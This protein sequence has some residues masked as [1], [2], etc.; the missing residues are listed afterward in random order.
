MDKNSASKNRDKQ[1]QTIR[2]NAPTTKVPI[3]IDGRCYK[4]SRF[5]HVSLQCPQRYRNSDGAAVK[6]KLHKEESVDKHSETQCKCGFTFLQT[7]L[8]IVASSLADLVNFPSCNVASSFDDMSTY[9]CDGMLQEHLVTV[10]RDDDCY[11][12]GIRRNLI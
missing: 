1:E 10:L 11:D 2:G 9:T 3:I 8:R 6:S 7:L 4:C 12:V 5:G